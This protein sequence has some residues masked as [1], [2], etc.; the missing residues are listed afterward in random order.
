MY[1]KDEN[2]KYVRAAP[3]QVVTSAKKRP[4]KPID[5]AWDLALTNR[6]APE[7]RESFML[8]YDTGDY[9]DT[10]QFSVLHKIVLGIIQTS[11]E[12]QMDASTACIDDVDANGRTSLSWAAARCDDAAVKTLLDHGANLDISDFE[13]RTPLA[14]AVKAAHMPSIEL[15]LRYGA[16]TSKRDAFGGTVLHHACHVKDDPRLLRL[17]IAA[18]VDVNAIDYDGDTALQYAVR[19]KNT[20]NVRCLLESSADPDIANV[21]GDTPLFMAIFHQ[22]NETLRILLTH[23]VDVKVTN[24]QRQTVLHA[25][26]CEGSLESMQA[27]KSTDLG[28]LDVLAKDSTGRTCLDYFEARNT[29]DPAI[30]SAFKEIIA[31]VRQETVEVSPPNTETLE[32]ESFADAIEWQT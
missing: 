31:L 12:S 29:S 10:R 13:G 11:L 15:L 23:G 21:E 25:V 28:W 19:Q 20:E 27:L 9:V 17:L 6:V 5:S 24:S 8:L 3:R 14:Q 26:A 1:L 32:E 7:D 18:G 16:N 2:G 4:R 22:A 30:T